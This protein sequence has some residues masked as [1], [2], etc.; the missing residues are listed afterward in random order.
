MTN[1]QTKTDTI[2]FPLE[3][4][5]FKALLAQNPNYFG[6]L[7]DSPFKPVKTI[8]GNT[9]Y[10]EISF[11][12]FNSDR[13]MLEASIKIKFPCRDEVEL[14]HTEFFEYIRFYIDYGSGWQDAG[15][16]EVN[17]HDLPNNQDWPGSAEKPK[18][19][20]VSWAIDTIR[21]VSVSPIQPRVRAILSW[22]QI[23]PPAMSNWSPVW[24]NVVD[25]DFPSDVSQ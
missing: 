8:L 5:S 22:N 3:R 21:R 2:P 1:N 15:L 7:L 14:C 11:V 13:T 24:G 16:A 18:T 25:Q 20:V 10:E 4:R 19:Y 6:N 23:P 12:E 9:T 17:I